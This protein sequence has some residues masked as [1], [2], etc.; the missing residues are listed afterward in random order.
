M[1]PRWQKVFA[2]LWGNKVRSLLVIASIAVG[3]YAVGL[4][5][6][7]NVIINED[8]RTGYRAL[9]PANLHISIA[10]FTDTLVEKIKELPEVDEAE[11]RRTMT[12]RY[13]NKNGEWDRLEL[14]AIPEIDE[15]AINKVIL[16]EG[17]W[18][19]KYRE[20]AIDIS[21][22]EDVAARLGEVIEI[23]LPS[24][25][26]REVRLT[27]IVH[28]QTIGATGGGGGYFI[29]PVNGYITMHT[30][31]W[32]EQPA[33][34]NALLVTAKSGQEDEAYLRELSSDVN[35]EIEDYGGVVTS[36]AV[37]TSISHPNSIYID[38]LSG[39]LFVLGMLIVFLSGFLIT[40][41]LSALMNQQIRQIG[42]M[43]TIGARRMSIIT[44]YMVLI[45][46]Y[47]AI[48][49]GLAIPTANWSAYGLANFLSD[50]L[51]FDVQGY[52]PI[53]RSVL[54]Q[55]GI[56]LIVPQ[57]AAFFPIFEGANIKTVQAISGG[58]NM[59]VE[60]KSDWLDRMI[61]NI[62]GIS[63][64][65]LISLRNT[66]RHKGRLAL[67][68]FT[69]TLGG[70]IFIATFNVQGALTL[71]IKQ[72]SKY[73]IA[74]VSMTMDQF[75][76]IDQVQKDL[77]SIPGISVVEG[78]TYA[79]CEVME[80]DDKPGEPVEM[81]GVAPDS[82]LITPILIKGRWI[83]PGDENA[84]VLSERFLSAY[85]NMKIGDT[86]RLRVNGIKSDWIVVGFFQLAGK[87]TGFRA[88]SNYEY[89]SHLIGSPDKAISFQ[90][91]STTPNLNIEQQRQFGAAIEKF[92]RTRGYKVASIN[93]GLFALNSSTEGLN[94]LTTF[95]IFMAFLTALVGAIGL[96]GTMSMNVMDRTREI[97]IMR[98]IGASDRTV[99]NLVIVEGLLIGIISWLL[100]CLLSFPISNWLNNVLSE[101][102]FDAPSILSITPTGFIVWL[103][104]VVILAVSASVLPARN[105]AHLTIREVL[106]YE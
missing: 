55:A 33:I 28:D 66:F 39:I 24:G 61:N 5:S 14:Q 35:K 71:Y 21:H 90:I 50:T 68:L 76:R 81:L 96:M 59:T 75:Y 43:K 11:G 27:G 57:V 58:R 100:S 97:G 64:P 63:H 83:I 101:A 67:T 8:M 98:A 105:A 13:R 38:A 12:L 84:I 32:L 19:P 26:T 85:P 9:N 2:D 79:R 86:L 94:I 92:M 56:A 103:V 44:I 47:G 4:I 95:L 53:L 52:R 69:L 1:R 46:M 15:M 74:D 42:V 49:L 18:P 41:T 29:A 60:K 40:N 34:Y 54:I 23:Q 93:A 31:D 99:M 72:V 6:S 106:S 51:N 17:S 87:S 70:S 48:A 3:L 20:I 82:K 102:L 36:T 45:A 25:K 65:L 91:S 30:L 73:F 88:Y 77:Q 37:R 78:W 10:A 89:L 62:K 22:R 80:A 16:R 7:I 104:L